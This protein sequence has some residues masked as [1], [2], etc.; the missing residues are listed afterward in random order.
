[1]SAKKVKDN[2]ASMLT[3]MDAM[4]KTAVLVGIPADSPKNNRDDGSKIENSE[5]GLIMEFGAP[6]ANIPPR[7]FLVPG[8][9]S[10]MPDIEKKLSRGAKRILT[11]PSFSP[12]QLFEIV[13]LTAQQGV[14]RYMTDA[15]FAPLAES[16]L[17]ARKSR[18]FQGEK[19]LIETGSLRQSITFVVEKEK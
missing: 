2:V 14:Q 19:P 4:A 13:G 10:V 9:N 16:T 3:G 1:M 15:H 17:A 12:E 7:P 18:G 11:D 5:I 8:I 6:E